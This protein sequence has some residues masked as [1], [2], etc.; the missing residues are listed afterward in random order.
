M[1]KRYLFLAMVAVGLFWASH[2][3]AI[4]K[5]DIPAS[6]ANIFLDTDGKM[7]IKDRAGN[8]HDLQPEKPRYTLRMVHGNPTGTQWGITFYF[9]DSAYG[10]TLERGTLYYGFIHHGDGRYNLPVFY[11]RAAQ[12]VDG[13]AGIDILKRLAGKYDLVNWQTTGKG[14]LGYRVADARGNLLY[15]GKIAFTGTGP[16]TVDTSIIEGPFVCKV[17]PTSAT[18]AFETNV[19]AAGR[20]F[21]NDRTFFDSAR[22]WHEIAVSGLS[23]DRVYTYTVST[24]R[25]RHQETCRF[26]TAPNSGARVP[27]VFAYAS[28]SRA[29]QGG[30]ERN[31]WGANAYMMKRIMAVV[32]AKNAAF[33]QFTGDQINGYT[34]SVSEQRLQYSNWK[35]AIEP[36]AGYTPVIT[37]MGNHEFLGHA[38]DDKSDDGMQCD[39]FPF[40]SES[41]EAVF[42]AAFVNPENGPD[43]E[44]GASYDPNPDGKDFPGYKE[45]VFY[46]TYD[47][48][49]VVVLNSNY[50]YSPSLPQKTYL[51]G[52]LHGYIMDNQLVWLKKTLAELEKDENID[53][54]FITQHTPA[55][56]N[57]GHVQDSMWYGG[58]NEPRPYVA[59][60]PV[61]KG[62]IERRDEY[63]KILLEHAKVVA[64]LTGDEH[65]Y[66]RLLLKNGVK[67][68]AED[69]YLPEHPLQIT[70][71]IWQIN[72]GAAGAP[73]YA[74][75]STFWYD[76]LKG[77]TTQSA[78]V[79]F[80]IHGRSLKMEVV[81]PETLDRIE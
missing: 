3:A 11:K 30:G 81:N 56:P 4:T 23:P 48:V 8:R 29:G 60:K 25:G 79:F 6:H 78:V 72:N 28:D 12:I 1:K 51:G 53:F 13:R 58:S 80:H 70:R 18:I 10:L 5:N 22:T 7:Y 46:Y 69:K 73:Y 34:N 27:F 61:A 14:T 47:N 38:W 15:D 45:N 54:V 19:P 49:A 24:D 39:R 77:F 31:I 64:M 35:R 68:Y 41:S 26:K 75:E 66:S 21:I 55:F 36:W 62:I 2:G 37:G 40:E 44:D 67:I 57:G 50:W 17:G 43:S 42:A 63:L 65:N 76:H 32:N 33:L 71:P 52:N 9:H 20:I 16:F 59:G 74:R